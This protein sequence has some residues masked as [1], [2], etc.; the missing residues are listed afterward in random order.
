MVFLNP[1][2]YPLAHG[3]CLTFRN[4]KDLPG[5]IG[6]PPFRALQHGTTENVRRPIMEFY[7]VVERFDRFDRLPKTTR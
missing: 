1:I 7:T 5:Q 3:E 2:K 4:V 6:E